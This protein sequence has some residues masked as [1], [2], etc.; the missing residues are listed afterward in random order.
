ML[1]PV[2][3]IAPVTTAIIALLGLCGAGLLCGATGKA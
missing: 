1:C 3:T 2:T